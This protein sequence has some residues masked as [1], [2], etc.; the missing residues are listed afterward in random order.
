[1]EI[2]LWW[3]LWVPSFHSCLRWL[4][5][6]SFPHQR[7]PANFVCTFSGDLVPS[8]LVWYYFFTNVMRKANITVNENRLFMKTGLPCP[9]KFFFHLS[10]KTGHGG[11][12]LTSWTYHCRV[13]WLSWVFGT[14]FS[15]ARGRRCHLHWVCWDKERKTGMFVGGGVRWRGLKSDGVSI[16][17]RLGVDGWVGRSSRRRLFVLI[18]TYLWRLT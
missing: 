7:Y 5:S 14:H 2:L 11:F 3:Q 1:M 18:F 9:S 12:L 13:H 6:L 4:R 16:C 8:R 10:I 17:R 15:G